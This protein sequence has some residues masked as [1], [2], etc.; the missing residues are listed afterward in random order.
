MNAGRRREW[1]RDHATLLDDK[2]YIDPNDTVNGF[3]R[4]NNETVATNQERFNHRDRFLKLYGVMVMPTDTASASMSDRGPTATMIR[5]GV[6]DKE[7]SELELGRYL[8]ATRSHHS[9]KIT[10]WN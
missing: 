4:I 2:F 9:I 1:T 10:M 5:A 7:L 6:R 8:D 3:Y